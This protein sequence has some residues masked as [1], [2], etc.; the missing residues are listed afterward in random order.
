M[1][2]PKKKMRVWWMHAV[3]GPIFYTEVF[4]LVQAKLLLK[5]LADYDLYLERVGL[6]GKH[7]NAG[8]L[9]VHDG[10][11]WCE[12]ESPTGDSIDDMQFE[13][14]RNGEVTGWI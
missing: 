5:T 3:P 6:V 12:W 4:T 7:G 2:P 10:K 13:V 8:G 11:E 1:T 9:E 14:V